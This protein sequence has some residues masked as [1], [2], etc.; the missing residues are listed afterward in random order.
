MFTRIAASTVVLSIAA[1]SL[2]NAQGVAS[3][4]LIESITVTGVRQRVDLDVPAPTASKTAD[5]LRAQNLV[6]PEDA[7]KYVP[8]LTIRK[9]YIGDRNV[10]SDDDARAYLAKERETLRKLGA[11]NGI[12]LD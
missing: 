4:K 3:D 11:S 10:R 2:A 5:D 12:K 9:R 8:N 7:L 1:I 6:N